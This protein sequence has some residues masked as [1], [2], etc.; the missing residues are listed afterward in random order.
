M[1]KVLHENIAMQKSATWKDCNTKKLQHGNTS[2]R[3][4]YNMKRMQ[5]QHEK[6]ITCQSETW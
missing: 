3:A 4:K 2:I 6:S 1:K 5:P